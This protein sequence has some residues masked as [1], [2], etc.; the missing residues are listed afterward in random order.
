MSFPIRMPG[1]PVSSLD[2]AVA[3]V[4][5][6]VRHRLSQVDASLVLVAAS[7][8]ADSLALAAATAFEAPRR[9]WRAGLVTIDHQLQEGSRERAEAL[10]K[11]ASSTGFDPAEAVTVGVG[12][13]GGPEAAARNARYTALAATATR[14]GASLVLLG[15]TEDDQ[16]ETVLL[17]LARGAG[18]RGLAA[19]P[20][21]RIID[22]IAFARPLLGVSRVTCREACVAQGLT[23]WDDPHNADFSY[24]RSRVRHEALP[25][26]VKALG[27]DVVPNL[28]RTAAM[29]AADTEYLDTEA[30]IGLVQSTVDGAL[31]VVVLQGMPDAV[32]TRVLHRWAVGLGCPGAALSHRHITALDALV[33]A[34]HGQGPAHLP[35][36]IAVR[37]EA[38]MLRAA[39]A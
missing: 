30:A 39:T 37:R 9:G 22:G 14:L 24:T 16:A 29:L 3:E 18:P 23:P 35:G 28:A 20:A 11:W 26:L 12:T 4:R 17:A 31:A 25:A 19:M 34:W 32:R 36:A 38:G 2:P 10:V 33:T 6:A 13:E 8:G 1:S 27:P 5:L 7:G 21:T 15:H